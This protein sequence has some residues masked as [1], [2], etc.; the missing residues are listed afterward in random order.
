[1]KLFTKIILTASSILFLNACAPEQQKRNI[2]LFFIDDLGWTDLGCYGSD[3]YET[4]NI[5]KLASEGVKFTDAYA[6]CTVCSPSRASVM[7]GK[8][9]ARL[10]LT[11]WIQGHKRPKAK[12]KVPDWQMYLDTTEVTIAK[13]LKKG[14]YTT[15]IFGKWHLGDIPAYW[16]ESHGFDVNIGG[17]R[18]GAPGSYFYPYHGNRRDKVHPPNLEKG[19]EGEYLT[20]RLTDEAIEFIRAQQNHPFFIYFPHYAVH[21]PIQAHDSLTRY[22]QNKITPA[23]RHQ[24][25]AYAAMIH[26]VDHSVK[27]IR[28]TLSELGLDENTAILFTSD[29]GG[30]ELRNIT[31]NGAIRAGKGS[32]YEG[33]V[34]VP[35]ITYVPGVTTAGSV[36]AQPIIGMDLYPTILSLAGLDVVENDGINLHPMFQSTNHKLNRSSIFWHYPHYHPGG[37]SPYSAIRNGNY[38]LIEFFEDGTLELYNLAEDIGESNNLA[39]SSPEMAN[40]LYEELQSWREETGAQYPSLNPIYKKELEIEL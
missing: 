39:K 12:L 35:F 27:R 29:N 36:S 37:A 2:I 4:P 32:A 34:R 14:G 17:Y 20:D 30:L 8:Y 6:A 24:N 26:S 9:P 22:Y 3:L 11:D 15:A 28:S 33:G 10:H 19:A 31:D 21:T 40:K 1:M 5:D 18:W 25:A 13:A 7:T 38:K 23:N 16:P